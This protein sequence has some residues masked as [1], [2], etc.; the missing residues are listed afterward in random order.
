MYA[1]GV[2]NVDG[3]VKFDSGTATGNVRRSG[4]YPAPTLLLLL[5]A[6]RRPCAGCILGEIRRG[7]AIDGV[8]SAQAVGGSGGMC[9]VGRGAQAPLGCVVVTPEGLPWGSPALDGWDADLH[10]VWRRDHVVYRD[11]GLSLVCVIGGG[12]GSTVV[13]A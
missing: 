10:T 4:S 7:A 12:G 8:P 5:L 6:S 13:E 2:L 1:S 3:N 11:V 9:C